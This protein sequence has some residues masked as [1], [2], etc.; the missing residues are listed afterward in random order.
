MADKTNIKVGNVYTFQEL[1]QYLANMDAVPP[2]TFALVE[3]VQ[4]S[5]RAIMHVFESN[6]CGD[7]RSGDG[8]LFYADGEVHSANCGDEFRLL[9][10]H[11]PETL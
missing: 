3:N 9:S 1:E 8:V 5:E 11:H 6:F 4:Y 2:G 10:I 7:W